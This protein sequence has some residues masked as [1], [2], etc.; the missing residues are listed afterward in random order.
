VSSGDHGFRHFL[1]GGG[2]EEIDLLAAVPAQV[3]KQGSATPRVGDQRWAISPHDIAEDLAYHFIHNSPSAK[4]PMVLN[5][6][7]P[8]LFGTGRRHSLI[9]YQESSGIVS[10]LR[11]GI[12][13]EAV[14]RIRE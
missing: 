5:L 12:G 11:A 7:N 1:L 10:G 14:S 2:Y 8:A 4:S 3:R 13:G 6:P 9:I